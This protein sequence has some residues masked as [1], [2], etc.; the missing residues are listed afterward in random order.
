MSMPSLP[1]GGILG[2]LGVPNPASVNINIMGPYQFYP[3]MN[4]NLI[5]TLNDPTKVK[6]K[7]YVPKHDNF[8]YIGLIIGP[9]GSNQKR[10]EEESQC[11]ILVRGKG[12]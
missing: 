2:Q 6:K 12:S 11:K 1:T 5:N 8:N 7:L 10:L 3:G 9:K 4:P